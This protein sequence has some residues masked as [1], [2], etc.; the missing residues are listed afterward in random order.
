MNVFFPFL[1]FMIAFLSIAFLIRKDKNEQ[2]KLTKRGWVK[3]GLLLAVV[4]VL[5][6]SFVLK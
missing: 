1:V 3:F 6:A 2:K 4:F 5:V